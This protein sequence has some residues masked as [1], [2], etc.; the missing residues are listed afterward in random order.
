MM[1]GF[2][3]ELTGC[4]GFQWDGGNATKNWELHRV[5][6]AEA[7][8]VFFNRPLLIAPDAGHSQHERRFAALGR[9][10]QGRCLLVIFTVRET[11]IRVI[12]AR[13]MSRQERRT[14]AKA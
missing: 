4:S 10:S 3:E 2:P 9:T 5:A 11:N 8:Q 1:A 6:Q 12:S 14:Y 13:E 7:E